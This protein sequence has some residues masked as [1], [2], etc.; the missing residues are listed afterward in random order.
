MDSSPQKARTTR[1]Y[2]NNASG[3]RAAGSNVEVHGLDLDSL[4]SP[5]PSLGYLDEALSYIAG[6]RA[7]WW[8]VQ[9]GQVVSSVVAV[10]G[11]ASDPGEGVGSGDDGEGEGEGEGPEEGDAG[12]EGEWRNVVGMFQFR[13]FCLYRFSFPP[14]FFC[15][16]IPWPLILWQ[17]THWHQL[18][19]FLVIPFLSTENGQE[20]PKRKRRRKRPP[21]SHAS[22]QATSG[23]EV[24]AASTKT[25]LDATPD[26]PSNVL[27]ATPASSPKRKKRSKSVPASAA[28]SAVSL[29]LD[30]EKPKSSVKAKGKEK[31]FLV[32]APTISGHTQSSGSGKEKEKEKEKERERP[33]VTILRRPVPEPEPKEFIF[34]EEEDSDGHGGRT[35]T[36]FSS[37][38][39]GMQRS[40]GAVL[41]G[42]SSSSMISL[43]GKKGRRVGR[44]ERD[45]EKMKMDAMKGVLDIGGG[46][47]NPQPASN[48][49]VGGGD[50][51]AEYHD[52][53]GDE[54]DED[55][56]VEP[57]EE[58]DENV[59]GTND[60]LAGL[61]LLQPPRRKRDRSRRRK[62]SNTLAGITDSHKSAPA[63]PGHAKGVISDEMEEVGGIVKASTDENN[64]LEVDV[65]ESKPNET[66]GSEKKKRTRTKR[67]KALVHSTSVPQLKVDTIETGEKPP[68]EK[69]DNDDV[70]VKTV[71]QKKGKNKV[72][73]VQDEE[74]ILDMDRNQLRQLITESARV[75][76]RL[77][78][79]GGQPPEPQAPETKRGRLL[80]L[81]RK[82]K[83]LFP[84][85]HDELGRVIARIEGT[86][87]A[88]NS[89]VTNDVKRSKAVS[90]PA[91][92]K[93][94][95]K[96]GGHVRTGSEGT[97][98]EG[99]DLDDED[100]VQ[101]GRP[102]MNAFPD[103]EEE[104]EEI[105]PRGRPP[106]KGDVLVHV[107]IDQ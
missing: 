92:K 102:A 37:I 8:A 99:F 67:V 16:Y 106:R 35:P 45:K 54:D 42:S 18:N 11:A 9:E 100:D 3:R 71:K 14:P 91:G 7:R 39:G 57:Q 48:A 47:V 24:P 36:N 79:A 19:D 81:A 25:T 63:T 10:A 13:Y 22:A 40:L 61:S 74:D 83:Q 70:S 49:G 50:F 87:T 65:F 86:E 41:D 30:S 4:E 12:G 15:F 43:M 60:S 6:E 95:P 78:L 82:L 44:K 56:G 55:E 53:D 20:Q 107:F 97:S 26:V 94:K 73:P 98:L 29:V 28:V 23:G 88:A 80:T 101:R 33:P 89:W 46:A 76:S 21:R 75:G 69:A 38:N 59:V 103:I 66:P 2:N 58:E 64:S 72:R 105:D 52:A 17:T 84:E 85:Q 32:P 1:P 93:K 104:D 77:L 96:K 62:G 31:E 51:G 5:L 68:E 90:I 27:P 34:S